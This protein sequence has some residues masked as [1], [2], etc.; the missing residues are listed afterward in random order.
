MKL[1]GICGSLRQGSYNAMA[2]RAAAEL[3]PAGMSMEIADLRGI[4]FYD[5]DL[6]TAEGEPAAVTQLKAQIRAADAVLIAT[7][8]YNFSIPGVLKNALDWVSRPPEPPFDDK[9]VALMGASPG[10]A[11]TGRV[12]YDLRKVMVFLNAFVVNKPEV[13]IREAASRFDA[14]G[15][16]VD[17]PTRKFIADLLVATQRLARRLHPD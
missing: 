10:L 12:Q 15:R 14:S 3:M 17:E 8:E 9:V 6:R 2:L 13:F 5:E 11:G 7:P 16:L 1:L 4:P